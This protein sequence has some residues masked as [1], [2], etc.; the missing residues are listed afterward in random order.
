MLVA[1]TRRKP[2]A[3]GKETAGLQT[4]AGPGSWPAHEQAHGSA[5]ALV[6]GA[7]GGDAAGGVES[8]AVVRGGAA[9]QCMRK[10][11]GRGRVLD[12]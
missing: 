10:R 6:P 12:E 1:Q 9:K 7:G 4:P 8:G 11:A 2:A 5:A 3:D